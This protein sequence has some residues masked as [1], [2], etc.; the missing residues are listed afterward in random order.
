M[1]ADKS[2]TGALLHELQRSRKREA[3]AP[4]P[5]CNRV[6]LTPRD[7][8]QKN[9]GSI[10]HLLVEHQF[11][12]S[13][14]VDALADHRVS[15]VPIKGD[16]LKVWHYVGGRQEKS[17]EPRLLLLTWKC[18]VLSVIC[19]LVTPYIVNCSSYFGDVVERTMRVFTRCSRSEKSVQNICRV[20]NGRDSYLVGAVA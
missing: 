10:P 9:L 12:V 16:D 6:H 5:P 18:K 20:V 15:T 19:S 7:H 2:A 4:A 3:E 13:Q 14:S 17:T 8:R 1:P 11:G